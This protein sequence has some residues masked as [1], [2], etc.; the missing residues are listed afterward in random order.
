MDNGYDRTYQLVAP[1]LK[2]CD[3]QEELKDWDFLR[4]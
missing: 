4:L 3:L 2:H 1:R